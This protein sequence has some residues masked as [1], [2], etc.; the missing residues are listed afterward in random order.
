MSAL[1]AH[2]SAPRLR[3]GTDR[4]TPSVVSTD[5]ACPVALATLPLTSSFLIFDFFFVRHLCFDS[6]LVLMLVLAANPIFR[7]S[8]LIALFFFSIVF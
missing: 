6:F 3:A 8:C 2:Y 7:H 1:P 5:A 4:S